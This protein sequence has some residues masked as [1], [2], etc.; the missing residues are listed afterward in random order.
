MKSCLYSFCLDVI[1]IQG[2]LCSGYRS[3]IVSRSEKESV[4]SVFSTS[5]CPTQV[6][7]EEFGHKVAAWITFNEPLS[8]CQEGYGGLDAPGSNSSGFEDYMC[9]HNVLRAHGMVYR[10]FKKDFDKTNGKRLG[11]DLSARNGKCL[12][13]VQDGGLLDASGSSS[14]SFED[15]M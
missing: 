14:S 3:R 10:M 7:L 15:Y 11:E 1:A 2:L 6:L 5:F 13:D 12:G 9:A 4:F 8:F